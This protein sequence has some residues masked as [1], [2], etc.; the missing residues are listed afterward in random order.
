MVYLQAFLLLAVLFSLIYYFLCFFCL[1]SFFRRREKLDE[2]FAPPVTVLKPIKGLDFQA[3]E[4]LRSFCL[5][6]YPQYQVIFGFLDADDPAIKVAESLKSSYADKD[7]ELAVVAQLSAT[8]PKV[9]NLCRMLEKAKYEVIVVSDSDMRVGPDYL[10]QVVLPLKPL[11]NMGPPADGEPASL[12]VAG[13][14]TCPY[15]GLATGSLAATLEA[16]SIN[17]GFTPSV[18]LAHRLTSLSAAFGST[19]VTSKRVLKEIGGLEAV[20]EY[21]A[22]DYQLADKVSKAGYEVCLL[23][24]VVDNV[25][26]GTD[27]KEMFLRRLR[28]ART[29]KACRPWGYLGTFFTHGTALSLFFL[30]AA[31]FSKPALAVVLG[32][33]GIRMTTAWRMGQAYLGCNEFYRQLWLLPLSDLL[34]FVIWVISFTGNKVSWRGQRFRILKGGRL[35]PV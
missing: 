10:R 24:Y 12:R 26:A 23:S 5:Q 30:A 13:L 16:L 32:T 8:N 11:L 18:V 25:I 33:I 29:I 9:S 15:R 2:G 19:M 6:D 34:D 22:D 7:I 4:N 35:A 27:Y 3:E 21:L 20:K 17:A 31:G 28:W 14:A 1:R